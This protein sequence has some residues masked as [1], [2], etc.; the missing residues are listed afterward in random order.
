MSTIESTFQWVDMMYQEEISKRFPYIEI[1]YRD[2][3]KFTQE[4]F[5][6][7][8]FSVNFINIFKAVEKKLSKKYGYEVTLKI[9][10][11]PLQHELAYLD[12]KN[13]GEFITAKCMIKSLTPL[14]FK[15][16]RGVYECKGCGKTYTHHYESESIPILGK[17]SECGSKSYTL[18]KEA[19]TY[20]NY[21][22]MKLVEPL[23]LRKGGETR[24]FKA[25]I[26]GHLASP[27]YSLNPGDVCD[28]AATFDVMV[29][30]KKGLVSLLDIYHI[31]PLNTSFD[32]MSLTES[33]IETI[34]EYSQREDIFEL[35]CNSIAPSVLGYNYVKEAL[36]LQMFEGARPSEYTDYNDR[37]TI[38]ILL[39]GD[40]GLGKSKIIEDV[41]ER[42]PRVIKANGAGTTQAGLTASAVKDEF[43]NWSIEAGGVVLAD[44]GILVIDEFDKLSYQVMK[45]LNEPMEQLSVSV[46]KA[47]LVQTMSARTSILAGANP[48][49]SRF[50]SYKSYD[51]QLNIPKSTIS[52]FDLIFAITD[53]INYEKDLDKAKKILSQ[54]FNEDVEVLS[55]EFMRKYVSYAKNNIFP[56]MDFMVIDKIAEF[57]AKTRQLGITNDDVGKPITMREMGVIYRLAVAR[58]KLSLRDFVEMEDVDCAIRIYTNSLKSLGLSL[59]T[60]GATQ[61]IYSDKEV[62]MIKYAEAYFRP[63]LTWNEDNVKKGIVEIMQEYDVEFREAR[64]FLEI[65]KE[66]IIKERETQ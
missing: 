10:N 17:C 26:E 31:K 44:G 42:S 49:Y 60:A 25:K 34:K 54:E 40:P 64:K 39:I 27:Y 53:S 29:D 66:N 38:H 51:E 65:G 9:S 47:G 41:Y 58:A 4:E 1:D 32:E 56:T 2:L 20:E 61:N 5:N 21:R 3:E 45:S 16:I 14:R 15:L 62:S 59:E 7:P 48:K 33:D 6:K 23:E 11:Y 52:R 19:S 18:L 12:K 57:Y 63:M 36:V 55:K 37:Y 35:F 50:D 46:A 30:D 28:M 13:I 24:E 22:Y 8:P 43:G